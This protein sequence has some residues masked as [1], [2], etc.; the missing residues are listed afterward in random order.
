MSTCSAGREWQRQVQ[1]RFA[2]KAPLAERCLHYIP[3]LGGHCDS[4]DAQREERS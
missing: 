2:R 1:C 3:Y 4:L